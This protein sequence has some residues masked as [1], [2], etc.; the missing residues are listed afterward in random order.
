MIKKGGQA[1]GIDL[2]IAAAVVMAGMTLIYLYSYQL[3]SR[4]ERQLDSM[5]AIGERLANALLTEGQPENWNRTSVTSIGIL[6]E[7]KIDQQKLDDWYFL[8]QQDYNATRRI[9][10]TDYQYFV[11]FTEPMFINSTYI[12]GIGLEPISPERLIQIT[13]FSL[14]QNKPVTIRIAIWS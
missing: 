9:F 4:G 14:Y 8:T 13:R 2:M 5:N 12:G 1:W 11:N 6:T 7:G 10:R 3:A